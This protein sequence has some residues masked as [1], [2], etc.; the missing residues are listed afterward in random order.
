MKNIRLI[1]TTNK[2]II[3]GDYAEYYE[4][5]SRALITQKALY[6]RIIEKDSL[7]LSADTLYHTDVDSVNNMLKAY[8]HVAFYKKDLQGRCDS[9]GYTTKDSSMQM[10]YSPILWTERGQATAKHVDVTVGKRGIFGFN[11][12]GNAFVIQEA[13]SL[14]KYNQIAGKLIQGFFKNDTISKIN[15]KGN[16]QILY[17][18]K[19]KKS[20]I[21]LN[22]SICGDIAV[23][24]KKGD[25]DK[26]SFKNKPE[27]SITPIKEVN[28]E[29]AKLK[30]FLWQD[31]KR[32][33]SVQD[34]FVRV[35]EPVKKSIQM[36]TE[37]KIEKKEM[38]EKEK[39]K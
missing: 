28:V 37:I 23:W 12:T 24:F 26:V 19:S 11:L 35:E 36:E 14:Q 22:K 13:D 18:A 38:V 25:L 4:K 30:G 32:P 2:S 21:G 34:L 31:K 29:E 33:R 3:Y 20:I 15:V 10:Y 16:A 5:G 7:F 1:D 6:C 8:H 17:Y 39:K 27:S 9:L